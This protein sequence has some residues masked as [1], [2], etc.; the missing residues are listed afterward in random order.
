MPITITEQLEIS[1]LTNAQGCLEKV[2]PDPRARP[3]LRWFKGLQAA[4]KIPYRKIRRRV[5]FDAEEVRRALDKHFHI[6]A[7][8]G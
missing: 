4:G 1:G 8:N 6:P 5:W 2:F 3:S 7:S